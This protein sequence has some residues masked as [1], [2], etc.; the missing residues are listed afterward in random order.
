MDREGKFIKIGADA[1][2]RVGFI[3]GKEKLT[4][5]YRF[6]RDLFFV[7]QSIC[8]RVTEVKV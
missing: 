8:R 4:N 7:S 5:I 3:K 2:H 1:F 6:C